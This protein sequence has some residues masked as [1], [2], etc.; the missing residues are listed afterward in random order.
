MQLGD[1][2]DLTE[3]QREVLDD[4]IDCVEHR[5]LSTLNA[6][7]R[8]QVRGGKACEHRVR[9]IQ[10]ALEV[11]EEH[12][13]GCTVLRGE[14]AGAVSC[15]RDA[16]NAGHDPL[17]DV[18]GEVEEQIADTVRLLVRA[19]PKCAGGERLYRGAK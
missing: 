5:D 17:P 12:I 8:G 7:R 6:A 15:T 19:P 11:A 13:G 2:D 18:A 3:M 16:A 10:Y 1:E 9:L 14:L 4:V